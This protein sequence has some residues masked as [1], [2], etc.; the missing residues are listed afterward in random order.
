MVTILEAHLKKKK[1]K[2]FFFNE[3]NKK[4]LGIKLINDEYCNFMFRGKKC[5]AYCV[6]TS[7]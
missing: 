2:H 5:D 3:E 1:K 4:E 6:C 7:V